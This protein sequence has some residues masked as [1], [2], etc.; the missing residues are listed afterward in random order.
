MKSFF[1]RGLLAGLLVLLSAT[2][3]AWAQ[4]PHTI[5]RAAFDIGSA[6]IKCKIADVD[7]EN[8]RVLR[9]IE[10]IAR[11]ADFA[12]SLERSK[13]RTLSQKVM[14]EGIAALKEMKARAIE[15]GTRQFSAVGARCFHEAANGR[16]YFSR[17][18]RETGLP[19]RIIS[20]QQASMLSY[21]AV[22]QRMN[23]PELKLLV[24][25][26]GGNSMQMTARNADASL[27]FYMD[28]M[29]SVSFCKTVMD[30][31]QGQPEKNSPNPISPG[32]AARALDFAKSYARLHVPSELAARIREGDMRVAGI[33]GVHYYCIP[34][35]MGV[36]QPLFT[37]ED[38]R[39]TLDRYVGRTDA[40]IDSPYAPTR[41]S[42]LILVLGYMDSLG[43]SS[44]TPL[45]VNEADGLLTAPEFW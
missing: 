26:I 42:D 14:D 40:E 7:V 5:R 27:A 10:E 39:R 19:A 12:L 37:R 2:V 38:V 35:L 13:R 4:S 32:Q 30:V 41:V 36:R 23:V 8:G 33:G 17:I 29:A 22:R 31:I 45:K 9:T 6:T 25:D 20:Q 28:E 21:H 16:D 18:T 1:S 11:K 34:E 44:V 43:I 24:W 15:R 3:P